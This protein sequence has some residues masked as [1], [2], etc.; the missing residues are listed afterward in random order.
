MIYFLLFLIWFGGSVALTL[1]F[2][3][4]KQDGD[5]QINSVDKFVMAMP[6]FLLIVG[7][8]ITVLWL[9]L[10]V[11]RFQDFKQNPWHSAKIIALILGYLT[12]RGYVYRKNRVP[13]NPF[14]IGIALV[15]GRRVARLLGP[16]NL[17]VWPMFPFYFDA[18][19]IRATVRSFDSSTKGLPA[20][21]SQANGATIQP[22]VLQE[23]TFSSKYSL[24]Y[25]PNYISAPA[26]MLYLENADGAEFGTNLAKQITA[27]SEQTGIEDSLEDA[28]QSA[29]AVAAGQL[30]WREIF[31]KPQI[32]A[33]YV[34]EGLTGQK[35]EN[36]EIPSTGQPDEQGLGILVDRVDIKEASGEGALAAGLGLGAK[37]QAEVAAE[38]IQNEGFIERTKSIKETLDVDGKTAA[39]LDQV[40]TGK[41]EKT[42]YEIQ[43]VEAA[44]GLGA[45]AAGL[46]AGK[47][48][49]EKQ[50]QKKKTPKKRRN[51]SQPTGGIQIDDKK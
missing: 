50:T 34:I 4:S 22:G 32:L 12:F 31:A 33:P 1:V 25:R 27:A 43:G 36:R 46:L 3:F 41:A 40:Q 42:I 13:A 11:Y 18:L 6:R 44:G 7:T 37:E 8:V 29:L 16:G 28:L 2:G 47:Q 21:P 26:L 49:Q 19:P 45:I 48:K 38:K 51:P 30:A 23:G 39:D 14:H 24:K 5:G 20:M 15:R 17:C 9:A 10:L 35:M